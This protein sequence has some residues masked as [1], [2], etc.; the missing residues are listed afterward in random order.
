MRLS[1]VFD[2]HAGNTSYGHAGG[3][4][5]H[6]ARP[7][8]Q[9]EM[10]LPRVLTTKTPS[11][12]KNAFLCALVSWWSML[13][14]PERERHRREDA[15]ERGDV[16]PPDFFAKIKKREHAKDGERDDFLDD[17]QLR[18][19]IDRVAPAIGRDHEKIFKECDAPA[20]ED[21]QPERRA[22]EFRVQI[23]IPRERHENVRA[24]QQHDGQPAGLSQVVHK[25]STS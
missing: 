23:A 19:G 4:F 2:L 1:V 3:E 15:H 13:L 16:V 25:F 5:S 7:I 12:M 8:K 17:F 9:N 18:D 6:Q 22:F 24:D 11:E 14:R 20:R 10:K 21:D